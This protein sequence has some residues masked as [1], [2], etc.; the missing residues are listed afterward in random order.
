MVEVGS[1]RRPVATG[2]SAQRSTSTGEPVGARST[3][4]DAWA[5]VGIW[6]S[7]RGLVDGVPFAA[8]RTTLGPTGSLIS[9]RSPH[10]PARGLHHRFR[11]TA[12]GVQPRSMADA[13]ARYL[14]QV[15]SWDL[16]RT[17]G[18]ARTCQE[19]WREAIVRCSRYPPATQPRDMASSG[20]LRDP[21]GESVAAR[22]D[23]G[24]LP[25]VWPGCTSAVCRDSGLDRTRKNLSYRARRLALTEDV[26]L[27][28]GRV[29]LLPSRS[30]G[31]CIASTT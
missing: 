19:R 9:M 5:Q 22:G 2:Y 25:R 13:V 23:A 29:P 14:V 10:W 31:C 3:A 12:A 17:D 16:H 28:I 6:I 18:S 7:I 11:P 15:G 26:F 30:S 8:G 4:E 20:V 1:G 21:P 27:G 24:A